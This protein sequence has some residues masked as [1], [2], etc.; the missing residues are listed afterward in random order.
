M[1]IFA[2]EV[3]LIAEKIIYEIG[4]DVIQIKLRPEQIVYMFFLI[5]CP[6]K[7]VFSE[8]GTGFGKSVISA[9]LIVHF[10]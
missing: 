6:A 3:V 2:D 4:G 10:Y 9:I 5:N 1:L 8:Q 7:I